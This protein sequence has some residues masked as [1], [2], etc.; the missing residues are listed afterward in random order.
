MA[1]PAGPRPS[2]GVRRAWKRN[3]P[4][5][6]RLR[7]RLALPLALLLGLAGGGRAGRTPSST[8]TTRAAAG[9]TRSV[10]GPALGS[11]N[12]S[13]GG[14]RSRWRPISGK[15]GSRGTHA[16][17][18]GRDQPRRPARRARS[19]RSS[20]RIQSHRRGGPAELRQPGPARNLGSRLRAGGLRARGRP[21]DRH[22][23][24][25]CSSARTSTSWPPAGG[26]DGPGR[27]PDG[28][29]PGQPGLLRR[30]AAHPL[31][32]LLVPPARRPEPDRRQ[33][34]RTPSTSAASARPGSGRPRPPS[35]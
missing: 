22:G 5:A 20:L 6:D 27:R 31:R 8:S 7:A 26:P 1:I 34:Q 21:D 2:S 35:R 32:P 10:L 9:G 14:P 3:D 4:R 29:P 25:D 28:R 19:I 13:D 30:P 23:H 15:A 16:A 17:A 24:R 18:R 33:H 11:A 12:F